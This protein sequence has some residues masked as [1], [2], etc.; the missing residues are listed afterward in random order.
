MKYQQIKQHKERR[1]VSLW[2]P[3]PIDTELNS[4]SASLGIHKGTLMR[5][6]LA[7]KVLEKKEEYNIK[8]G[9]QDDKEE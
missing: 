9:I 8:G 7:E 4:M 5:L 3:R 1:R 2:I 6:L